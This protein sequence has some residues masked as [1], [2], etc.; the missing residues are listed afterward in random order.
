MKRGDLVVNTASRQACPRHSTIEV[1]LILGDG[2]RGVLPP[3]IRVYRAGTI[4]NWY[5][6]E[7]E[8]LSSRI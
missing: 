4:E 5:I 6:N 8:Y 7:I 1:G 3:L 2:P